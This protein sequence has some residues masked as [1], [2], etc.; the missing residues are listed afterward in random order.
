MQ[1]LTTSTIMQRAVEQWQRR[2]SHD[3]LQIAGSCTAT[4]LGRIPLSRYTELY[5]QTLARRLGK[6]IQTSVQTKGPQ[7]SN[8]VCEVF[9]VLEPDNKRRRIEGKTPPHTS[10]SSASSPE[11]ARELSQLQAIL[12]DVDQVTPRVQG[13]IVTKLPNLFS[14]MKIGGIDVCRGINHLRIPP[15]SCHTVLPFRRALGEKG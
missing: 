9:R 13:P 6:I 12:Q 14:N 3:H 2:E 11:T 15:E 8:Q 7:R 4:G 10:G 1:M 5:T